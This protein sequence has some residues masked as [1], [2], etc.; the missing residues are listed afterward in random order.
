MPAINE[1]YEPFVGDGGEEKG[2]RLCANRCTKELAWEAVTKLFAVLII[3]VITAAILDFAVNKKEIDE[4]RSNVDHLQKSV[5]VLQ[6]TT[7]RLISNLQQAQRNLTQLNAEIMSAE[8]TFST[9]NHTVNRTTANLRE[10][11]KLRNQVANISRVAQETFFQAEEQ[12]NLTERFIRTGLKNIT[13][14]IDRANVSKI[15][16]SVSILGRHMVRKSD[17][18]V[19]PN[20][21]KDSKQFSDVCGANQN[22]KYNDVFS[23]RAG[24]HYTLPDTWFGD[25]LPRPNWNI[26]FTSV[27]ISKL[28]DF[29]C[30]I[31]CTYDRSLC[32]MVRDDADFL[33]LDTKA[34]VV[35]M[36]F[37][38]NVPSTTIIGN[39]VKGYHEGKDVYSG[40]GKGAVSVQTSV[41]LNLI[42]RQNN[43]DLHAQ[44]FM[45]M[46]VPS[47]DLIFTNITD[48]QRWIHY[49][50]SHVGFGPGQS[51]GYQWTFRAAKPC[52]IKF[53]M[54]LP[55]VGFGNHSFSYEE[56]GTTLP[57]WAAW[58]GP[59]PYPY[60]DSG[61]TCPDAFFQKT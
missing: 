32:K 30:A 26:T 58:S 3:S 7:N 50:S 21:L 16:D 9:L 59:A 8:R 20:F 41:F 57:I 28:G 49:T 23:C 13:Q 5:D 40:I 25:T 31:N 35:E 44:S 60:C 54:M 6:E 56:D 27:P 1:Q 24:D 38:G 53:G 19:T 33:Y 48:T 61:K 47:D 36:T 2:L 51:F 15:L 46:V 42:H 55:Y 37:D 22:H 52:A 43:C 17:L 11:R 12:M 29:G 14:E 39:Y 4:I 45:D 34:L 18:P 10:V